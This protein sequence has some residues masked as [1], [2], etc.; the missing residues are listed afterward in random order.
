MNYYVVDA[1]TDKLFSGN[2]AGVC[3]LD[4]IITDEIMQKIAFENNLSETAFIYKDGVKY[5]LRWFTPSF[6]IDLC[7]H[8]TLAAAFIVLN[9]IEP[10]L[11]KIEFETQSGVL[12]VKRKENLY[13]MIFPKR[14]PQQVIPTPKIIELLGFQPVELYSEWDLYAVMKNE[15]EVRDYVP[16]YA[17]LKKLSSWLGIV[18]TARGNEADFVSRYFCP[19]LMLEDPV[20]GS[21]HSTLAPIWSDKLEK[22]KLSAKQVSARSG[23]LYCEVY[24][25]NVKISGNA[26]LYSKG[27]TFI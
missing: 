22:E 15:Q 4:E 20:T 3:V 5:R 12:S 18:I 14:V 9:Y 13:E 1:F 25:D 6:E 23:T 24:G 27:K 16:D 11:N 2:P 19:E 7:G 26:I 17:K 21:T 8:A 10:D